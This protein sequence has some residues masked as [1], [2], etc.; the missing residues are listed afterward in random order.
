MTR[1]WGLAITLL[2][3]WLA[4]AGAAWAQ[5]AIKIGAPISMSPPGSVAQGKEVRDGL[6]I[7]QEMLNRKGVL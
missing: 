4:A 6:T 3:A 1:R 2:A 5:E 7:A